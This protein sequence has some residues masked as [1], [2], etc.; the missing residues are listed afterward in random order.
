MARCH[1]ARAFQDWL[2]AD[3]STLFSQSYRF[4]ISAG[5]F[6]AADATCAAH[7]PLPS[8]PNIPSAKVCPGTLCDLPLFYRRAF[9]RPSIPGGKPRLA[10]G[11]W[12]RGGSW[13]RPGA[14]KCSF[15]L[16]LLIEQPI[17][18]GDRI[19]VKETFGDVVKI[20][21]RSTWI[22]T[23]SSASVHN[24]SPRSDDHLKTN[25][26]E[27]FQKLFARRGALNSGGFEHKRRRWWFAATAMSDGLI[28]L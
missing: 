5:V 4:C 8:P 23:L 26:Q 28:L 13:R 24:C 22:R 20:G 9:H 7:A 3:S 1:L 21:A 6:F 17:R 19:E 16:I 25:F 15:Q 12:R 27:G 14:A 2:V 11:V 10:G 18:I